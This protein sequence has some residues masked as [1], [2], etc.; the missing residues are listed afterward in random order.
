MHPIERHRKVVFQFSGGKDSIACLELLRPYWDR[1]IVLWLNTGDPLPELTDQID[2]VKAAVPNFVEVTTD[3]HGYVEYWGYPV[4][5]LPIRNHREAQYLTGKD[6]RPLQSFLACCADNIMLPMHRKTLELG[7]TLIIR[8]Q[9]LSDAHKSPVR[10]GDVLLGVEYYFPL[11]GWTD[12]QVFKQI[13]GSEFLPINYTE[14]NQ[15]LEC[16]HCTA[17]AEDHKAR[18]QYLEKF[19]PEK[20]AEVKRRIIVIKQEIMADLQHME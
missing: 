6:R 14:G 9:K 13:R 10:S 4:D 12:E 3:S 1:I 20:A 15:S 18:R 17:Y 8:G 19:H 2:R 5:V 11:E 7:A 16:W